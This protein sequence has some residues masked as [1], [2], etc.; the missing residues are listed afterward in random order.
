MTGPEPADFSRYAAALLALALSTGA[1]L[2]PVAAEDRPVALPRGA[3][4][5]ALGSSFTAG[6]GITSVEPGTPARC[7][8]STDNYA[9]QLARRRGLDLTDASCSGATTRHLLEP[10]NELPAQLDALRPDTRL[11]TVTI[12]GNDVG[13]VSLL[14]GLSCQAL[15]SAASANP[16][17]IPE[18]PTEAEFDAL[19]D[20]L[21]LIVEGVRHRSPDALLVF[22][23]YVTLLPPSGSCA[24]APLAEADAVLVRDVAAKLE[25]VTA[26]AA[27]QG[28]AWLLPA[29]RLTREH[30]ACAA[31]PWV[32]GFIAGPV[33]GAPVF[34]AYHPRLAAMAAIAA[35]LD[36]VLP[37]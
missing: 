29:S 31:D 30:H 28:N 22:V 1:M 7:T 3:H 21:A 37:R 4:Y 24:G 19:A 18:R 10:W 14:G 2:R 8:R 34:V 26:H 5:V 23:D 9:R 17:R 27:R 6:P 20:R 35:E 12:G 11:V 25:R 16:C 15:S 33:P 36:R 32:N 13:Y